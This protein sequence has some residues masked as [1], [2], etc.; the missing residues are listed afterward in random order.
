MAGC[1]LFIATSEMLPQQWNALKGAFY[2]LFFFASGQF[3][4]TALGEELVDSEEF[5]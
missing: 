4:L 2:F 1:F 3:K 5:S